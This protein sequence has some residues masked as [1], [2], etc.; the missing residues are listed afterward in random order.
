MKLKSMA[1]VVVWGLW[2][3]FTLAGS[4][5]AA[6]FMLGPNS[7]TRLDVIPSDNMGEQL[8]AGLPFYLCGGGLWGWG[9]ARLMSADA[10]SMV[11]TCALSWGATAF[12]FIMAVGRLGLSFG[13]FSRISILPY[14]GHSTHYN[15][16]AIFV[17]LIGIITAI[18]GYVVTGKLGFHELKKSAGLYAGIAAALGFLAVGLIL[19]YGLGWEVGRPIF[20][21]YGMLLLLLICS[22]GAALAGGMA[23]GW[24]LDKPRTRLHG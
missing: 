23:I 10:K 8:L 18:N 14:F 22:I 5:W 2:T 15:F 6:L 4:V 19:L 9:I 24:V 3:A 17:P 16:L 1:F 11:K 21:K 12:A 13:G 20:G 7:I